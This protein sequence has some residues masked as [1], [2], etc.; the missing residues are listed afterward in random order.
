MKSDDSLDDEWLLYAGFRR[1]VIGRYLMF[2]LVD[3]K[4]G[5]KKHYG[6]ADNP[7]GLVRMPPSHF[8]FKESE[9][10]NSK[11][12]PVLNLQWE[13]NIFRKDSGN[14]NAVL[15]C[16]EFTLHLRLCPVLPPMYVRGTGL[17]GLTKPESL[18]YY[19]FPG[20]N[21]IGELKSD[22]SGK[23]VC[24]EFWYEH[25]WGSNWPPKMV[26]WSLWSLQLETGE[27]MAVSLI[28]NRSNKILQA[29]I[30]LQDT[31]GKTLIFDVLEFEIL[32]SWVSDRSY[33][34]YPV[35]WKIKVPGW[36][37]DLKISPFFADSEIP[38]LGNDYLWVG[39]CFVEAV[40]RRTGKT[41]KGKGLQEN[42]GY[43]K[44]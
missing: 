18:H 15:E 23:K 32:Q 8:S 12:S 4:T 14:Y 30:S 40:N 1:T 21:G 39:P 22:S 10:K 43:E 9:K 26:K 25:L 13:G 38:V 27:T 5:E 24:G 42:G 28:K 41:I 37:Y 3:L 31:S 7:A 6:F 34:N 11:N 36:D 35:E 20:L 16:P 2:N 19:A 17:A 33:I 29:Y 44:K